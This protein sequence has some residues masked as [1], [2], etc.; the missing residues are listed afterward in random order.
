ALSFNGVNAYVT[1]S[2]APSL[3]LTGDLT[4]TAWVKGLSTAYENPIVAKH[5]GSATYDYDFFLYK[6]RAL[7]LY[8]DGMSPAFV[9]S[10]VAIPDTTNW[11]HVAVTRKSS[12]VTFYLD[13]SPAG[14]ASMA[15]AFHTNSSPV[16]IGCDAANCNTTDGLLKGSGD[17]VRIY[18]RALS[19]SE[20]QTV[21]N[22][23]TASSPP[24][25]PVTQFSTIDVPGST[26]SAAAGINIGGLIVGGFY[27]S[28]G[29]E[30]G[31]LYNKG[32]FSTLDVPGASSTELEGVNQQ[33]QIVGVYWD[34]IGTAHGALY[35]QGAFFVMDVP[36]PG[37]TDT[38]AYGINDLG[39]I[40][41][42]YYGSTGD[43][44]LIAAPRP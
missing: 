30:H 15:G 28:T 14:T 6:D 13:G 21:M 39:Y 37:A 29:K 27:E 32:Q 33:G 5:N 31:F 35:S 1:V 23:T 7:V 41:G 36:F 17:E 20:I 34:S 16:D 22:S 26:G 42:G 8:A 18:N 10:S 4:I 12:S 24:P 44:G 11:H 2:N 38:A 9:Q 43:N 25:Q 19:A 3:N 40:V